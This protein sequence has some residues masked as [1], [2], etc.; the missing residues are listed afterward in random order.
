VEIGLAVKGSSPFPH[1][2][3]S[4]YSNAGGSYIPMAHAYPI[5]GYEVDV[6]PFRPEAAQ[7]VIDESLALLNELH[8]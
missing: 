6:T 8:Q 1:T 4:G 2:L 3:F 5:G 7:A